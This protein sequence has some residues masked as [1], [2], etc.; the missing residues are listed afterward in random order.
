MLLDG[1]HVR[2]P[3]DRLRWSGSTG[4]RALAKVVRLVAP[5]ATSVPDLL[6]H[7]TPRQYQTSCRSVRHV[8]QV[9]PY[10]RLARTPRSTRVGG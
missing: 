9:A 3:V 2:S 7:H 1:L 6:S 10:A 5:Y 8:S 4:K